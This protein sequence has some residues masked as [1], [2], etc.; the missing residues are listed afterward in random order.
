M[1]LQSL[2]TD[3]LLR[4]RSSLVINSNDRQIRVIRLHATAPPEESSDEEEADAGD[5]EEEVEDGER[6]EAAKDDKMETEETID[7]AEAKAEPVDEPAAPNPDAGSPIAVDE[8]KEATPTAEG[9]DAN[10][11]ASSRAATP[12]PR[13]PRVP[14]FE[15]LHK[16]Q[17][18]VNR[19]PWN[20]C[21]FSR[22]GDLII[23]GAGH[24]ASHN[25]YI[26]DSDSGGLIKIL[27]GPKDPLED[28]DVSFW[29]LERARERAR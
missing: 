12:P 6:E 15:V 7:T 13:P 26:W 17:D 25:V 19:T 29:V 1:V 5:D 16:F 22:D 24:K 23:G 18:L 3:D 10:D 8:V 28:L 21:G 9:S 20:G 11:E 27:E 2:I 14:Y 4:L